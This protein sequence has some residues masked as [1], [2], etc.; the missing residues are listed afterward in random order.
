MKFPPRQESASPAVSVLMPTFRHESFVAR[1][2]ESLQAQTFTDWELIIV[3]DGSPDDTQAAVAP[4]C[5]VDNRL[6]YHRWYRNRG[7]GAALNFAVSQARGRYLAYLPSDDVYDPIHLTLLFSV[8]EARPDIYL[9]YGGVRWETR[10]ARMELQQLGGPTLQGAAADRAIISLE[11]EFLATRGLALI[12][13]TLEKIKG[14]LNRC[15][16]PS[17]IS[18]GLVL[19][20]ASSAFLVIWG[21]WRFKD[22]DVACGPF[23]FHADLADLDEHTRSSHA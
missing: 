3:D 17:C 8:L 18:L 1:A 6:V 20:R 7:L 12:L 13:R 9:A 11:C 16:S 14:R 2:L 15:F 19:P 5:A 4:Y 10:D 22:F 21:F 23:A